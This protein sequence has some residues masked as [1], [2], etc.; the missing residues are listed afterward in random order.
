MGVKFVDHR[1]MLKLLARLVIGHCLVMGYS[2]LLT[3]FVKIFSQVSRNIGSTNVGQV[4][5]Y[6]VKI[7]R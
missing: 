6:A 4:F 7:T 5:G 2:I 1:P 3:R